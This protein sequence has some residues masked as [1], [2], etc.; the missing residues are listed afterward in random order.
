MGL[1]Q[2][3]VRDE[4]KR[5][6]NLHYSHYIFN[7][8]PITGLV[9]IVL[10]SLAVIC[11]HNVH[12]ASFYDDDFTFQRRDALTDWLAAQEKEFLDRATA[13]QVSQLQKLLPACIALPDATFDKVLDEFFANNPPVVGRRKRSADFM[14]R[15]EDSLG[16]AGQE[17]FNVERR[18]DDAAKAVVAKDLT[19]LLSKMTQSELTD[20]KERVAGAEQAGAKIENLFLNLTVELGKICARTKASRR[21]FALRQLLED[22]LMNEDN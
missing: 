20:L 10:I 8:N 5:Q 17:Y 11:E 1:L 12:G 22:E 4:Y 18:A 7:M 9:A 14:R 21:L 3:V 19:K 2:A 16:S 13:D 6:P 15:F